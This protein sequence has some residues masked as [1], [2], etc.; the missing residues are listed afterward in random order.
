MVKESLE[1]EW[2]LV[3]NNIKSREDK[4]LQSEST[5]KIYI[6]FS[7]IKQYK[8][9]FLKISEIWFFTFLHVYI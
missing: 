7:Q 4:Q 3:N 5:N 6:F 1:A 8:T 9:T 2:E